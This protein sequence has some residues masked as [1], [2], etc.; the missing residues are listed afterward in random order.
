M[1]WVVVVTC[2][3]EAIGACK[4][5]PPAEW[6]CEVAN[7]HSDGACWAARSLCRERA[8]R[9][10]TT[11]EI[12]TAPS[13]FDAS[14]SPESTTFL[15]AICYVDAV[16]CRRERDATR[17]QGALGLLGDCYPASEGKAAET[18]RILR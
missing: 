3:V 9:R 18:A 14:T 1:R 5:E 10:G 6:W 16:A 13:C 4:A 7:D 11:C 8:T 2:A 15:S 17:R 12:A